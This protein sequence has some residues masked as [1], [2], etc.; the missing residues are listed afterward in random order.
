MLLYMQIR[1]KK[2]GKIMKIKVIQEFRGKIGTV[3][4]NNSEIDKYYATAE[5]LT[6][7]DGL[8]AMLQ[9]VSEDIQEQFLK[10]LGIALEKS[11]ED[12]YDTAYKVYENFNETGEFDEAGF[13]KVDK[14]FKEKI[15]SVQ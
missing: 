6:E 13:E 2:R 7:A 12:I 8:I 1:T 4:Y 5:I 15:K 10:E 14:I 11:M 9:K 3:E